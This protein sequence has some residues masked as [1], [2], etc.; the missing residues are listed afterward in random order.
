M[1]SILHEIQQLRKGKPMVID[2]S[3]HNRY[4]VVVKESDGTKTAYYFSAPIYN[5]YTR[6]VV[7]LQFKKNGDLLTAVGSNTTTTVSDALRMENA[8]GICTIP[9]NETFSYVSEKELCSKDAVVH[10]TLNGVA[11]R[12]NGTKFAF[13]LEVNEPHLNVRANDKYFSLMRSKFQQ[14]VI[15]S[16]IGTVNDIGEVIAPARV[17]Y[18]KINDFRY[19]L[20]VTSCSPMGTGIMLEINLY[21]GKLIQDTTVESANPKVNNAFGSTAFVGNTEVFGKQWLYSKL[22]FDRM[23]ELAD[24][25][26]NRAIWYLP[27]YNSAN[28]ALSA[29]KVASRFCSFGSN[30]GNKVAA[31]NYL[32]STSEF[33]RYQRMDI[34]CALTNDGGG[35]LTLNNGM[36]LKTA[37]KGNGFSAIA[38][39]DSYYAP[40]IL[41][42]N[43]R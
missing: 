5:R 35:Y 15:V 31:G 40:Q 7:D 36:I 4:R 29:Y 13:N 39:G 14:F 33:H 17:R 28:V 38:T 6:K 18:Q 9:L 42:V 30:W 8:E 1:N 26:I 43:F 20:T 21:E 37:V 2:Y 3:N 32:S 22:D 27:K 41:E 23:P 11:V 12:V 16:C 25:Y 10:P 34:T 24:K 19:A